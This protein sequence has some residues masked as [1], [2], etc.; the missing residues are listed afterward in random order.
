MDRVP[1]IS[2]G[3]SRLDSDGQAKVEL[4]LT[5]RDS[6][7]RMRAFDSDRPNVMWSVRFAFELLERALGSSATL[8]VVDL[9][10]EYVDELL[11]C[12]SGVVEAAGW[13]DSD[14]GEFLDWI[15]RDVYELASAVCSELRAERFVSAVA[16]ARSLHERYAYALAAARDSE[17]FVRYLEHLN[18]QRRKGFVG[19]GRSMMQTARDVTFRSPEGADDIYEY[20]A[21]IYSRTDALRYGFGSEAMHNLIGLSRNDDFT[22]V[23][24]S[25]YERFLISQ[26][27][28]AL[29]HVVCAV[30]LLGQHETAAWRRAYEFTLRR[31]RV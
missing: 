10:S 8:P 14:Q 28:Q 21:E 6:T 24:H 17:F 2:W 18:N 26:V 29:V 16:L 5:N 19:R 7:E 25:G 23:L 9:D 15:V 3:K 20:I 1:T 31:D 27:L 11:E 4:A 12:L 13:P 30:H 22:I